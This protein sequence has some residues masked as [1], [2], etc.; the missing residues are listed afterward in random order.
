MLA[1]DSEIFNH[2]DWLLNIFN[3]ISDFVFFMKVTQENDFRYLFMNEAA[4]KYTGLNENSIGKTVHEMMPKDVADLIVQQYKEAIQKK[5]CVTYEDYSIN[6]YQNSNPSQNVAINPDELE[7]FESKITPIINKEGICTNIIAIVR[8]ITERKRKESALKLSE[9]KYRLIADNMTDLV[10]LIDIHGTIKYASPSHESVLGHSS[11]NYMGK[12]ALSFIHPDDVHK[13]KIQSIN[14]LKNRQAKTIEFRHRSVDNDWIWMEGKISLVLDPH[15]YADH[16][17]V[18]AREIME[19]KIFEEKLR[20]MAFHDTLTGLPNRRYFKTKLIQS[21][22][23]IKK[24]GQKIAVMYI[25]IDKFKQVNDTLGHDVGDELLC[26]FSK[27]VKKCLRKYDTLAR[28]GGDEFCILLLINQNDD[29]ISI[30][31]RIINDI[32]E[33]WKI[34]TNEFITTSSIGISFYEDGMDYETLLKRADIALYQAKENGRNN[35]QIYS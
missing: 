16:F 15:G 31:K 30:A 9:E 1:V 8:D 4:K 10:T 34:G 5:E 6:S 26:Q 14:L 28:L 20:H 2:V 11:E 13:I 19:R 21:L 18:V 35:F 27:K 7:Y 3:N 22:N 33:K 24:C 25:D 12:P 32:Q 23:E 29:A 17:L